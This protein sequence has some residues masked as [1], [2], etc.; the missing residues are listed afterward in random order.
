MNESYQNFFLIF[1]NNTIRC[2]QIGKRKA[3]N[4]HS[5]GRN[6][7]EDSRRNSESMDYPTKKNDNEMSVY[8][9]D[10]RKFLVWPVDKVTMNSRDACAK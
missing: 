3:S 9:S 5:S 1:F 6:R 7:K 2:K 8:I 4:I 10:L